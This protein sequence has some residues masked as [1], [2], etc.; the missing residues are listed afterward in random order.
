MKKL[1]TV[2]AAL[3]LC[4]GL[5]AAQDTALSLRQVRDPVQLRAALNANALDAET[6]LADVES[7][8]AVT[9]AAAAFAAA[10]GALYRA[11][12]N[13]YVANATQLVYVA[14][15]VTNVIDADITH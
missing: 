11:A 3:A 5:Y 2:A 9:N 8:V 1:M 14:S 12:A 15:G 10:T 6:R 4:A 13:L 7:G